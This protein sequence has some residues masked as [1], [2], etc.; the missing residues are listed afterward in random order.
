MYLLLWADEA[1]ALAGHHRCGVD[2]G[3]SRCN[4]DFPSANHTVHVVP[5]PSADVAAS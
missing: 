3:I 2:D 4:T 5:S 1:V